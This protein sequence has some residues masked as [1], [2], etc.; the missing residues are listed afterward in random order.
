[1]DLY[2]TNHKLYQV[3][4]KRT[5][6]NIHFG[7]PEK[8]AVAQHGFIMEQCIQLQD[9]KIPST[10]DWI[11]GEAINT[12]SLLTTSIVLSSVGHKNF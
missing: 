1:M 2:W 8:S 3:E 7:Q 9:T 6:Q 12:E 4:V 10:M 5:P 11:T